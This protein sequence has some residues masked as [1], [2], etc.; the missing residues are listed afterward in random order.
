VPAETLTQ[1]ADL[2]LTHTLT[3][4]SAS[5]AASGRFAGTPLYMA[6]EALQAQRPTPLFDLWS[7]AVVLYEA[8]AGHHPFA[9][10]PSDQVLARIRR[11]ECLGLDRLRAQYPAACVDA[12]ARWLSP[13]RRERPATARALREQLQHWPA[14]AA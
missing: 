11:G 9:G 1:A 14:V 5:R 7:T 10:G 6:P 12:L 8:L 13:E 2:A 4:S 3:M